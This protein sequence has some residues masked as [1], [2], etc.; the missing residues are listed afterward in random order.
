VISDVIRPGSRVALHYTLSL[1]DGTVVDSTR[2]SDPVSFVIGNGELVD[3]LETRLLG[4]AA[5]EQRHFEI[6]AGETGGSGPAEA[7]Q[8][9]PRAE[10]PQELDLQPGQVIGFTT[11][12][13]QEV[14]GWVQEVSATE[15]VVD[16][17][18]PLMGRDLVF[19]VEI[20]SVEPA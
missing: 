19:D 20:L 9:L 18:H 7:R 17:S 13:G 3:F 4:L 8:R 2:E 6:A 12:G 5:A 15:V 16:F 10:F 11:P 14:P 1:K